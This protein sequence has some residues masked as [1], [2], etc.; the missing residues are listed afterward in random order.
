MKEKLGLI[1]QSKFLVP[2]KL[3]LKTKCKKKEDKQTYFIDKK[4]VLE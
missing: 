1:F 3:S 4:G 2:Q